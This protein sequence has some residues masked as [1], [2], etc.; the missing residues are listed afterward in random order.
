MMYV[1]WSFDGYS[2]ANYVLSEVRDPVWTIKRAAPAA[3]I[4][5]TFVYMLANLA[6]FSV[7]SKR[8]ILEGGQIVAA[9]FFGN[10]FGP[11]TEKVLSLVIS[12]S[13]LGNVLTVFF[14]QSRVIQELGREGILPYSSFFASS[15]PFNAPL[16]GLSAQWLIASL[17]LISI[18]PGDAFLFMLNCK[19]RLY[20]SDA[21]GFISLRNSTIVYLSSDKHSCC[22]G[23]SHPLHARI[24]GLE[25]EPTLPSI[26]M[27]YCVLFACQP[28]SHRCP[29]CAT[30]SRHQII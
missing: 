26:Q 25:L 24:Q 17:I 19:H 4:A 12:L 10:L 9:L 20:L 30:F 18:P 27:D 15:E 21:N 16:P 8:D 29:V 13:A 1:M 14:T 2:S 3:I 23:A 11:A 5:V 22:D 6:Y 7:V 28:V